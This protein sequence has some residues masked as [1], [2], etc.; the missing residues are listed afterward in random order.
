MVGAYVFGIFPRSER[1]IEATRRKTKDLSL[2]IDEETEKL[3][4]LQKRA[5]L[6]YV[7]DPLLG[8]DDMLRP[9][10][11]NFKGLEINGINRFFET[12]TFYRVPL[13]KDEISCD[14]KIT[15]KNIHLKRLK[16]GGKPPLGVLPEPLTFALMC[17]DENYGKLEELTEALAMALSREARTL[18][19]HGFKFLVLKAPYLSFIKDL[20][21]FDI[22]FNGIKKIRA[23]FKGPIM[24]HTYFKDISD[25]LDRLFDL[26][27]DGLGL[28]T[29]NTKLESLEGHSFKLLAL[30]VIDGYNTKIETVDEVVQLI[31]F[32]DLKL[33][34]KELYLT[35]NVDLEYVPQVFALRKVKVLGKALKKVV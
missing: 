23:A 25:R 2:I 21:L 3:I 19:K 13:V 24:L 16:A 8:W 20:S 10:T 33:S 32:A 5:D 17:R 7:E 11:V 27:V 18:T 31:K 4:G 9:Y 34:Y 12:N 1:L 22:A 15:I 26:P 6:S 35:N 29:F 14:G 28:D 30:S